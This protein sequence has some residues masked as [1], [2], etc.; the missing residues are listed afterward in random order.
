MT[1]RRRT[2]RVETPLWRLRRARTLTQG[3]FAD[4][5]DISQQNYSKYERGVILPPPERQAA[6]AAYLGVPVQTLWPRTRRSR[7]PRSVGAAAAQL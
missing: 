1:T 6:I 2:R 4:L 5:L 3:Q 7:R